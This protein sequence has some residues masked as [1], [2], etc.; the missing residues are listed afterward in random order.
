MS[1]KSKAQFKFM[2]MLEH[3]PEKMKDKPDMTSEQAAE[4][5]KENVGK[6]RFGKLIEKVKSKK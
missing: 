1:A 4:Y 6:K 3:N 5:T 2:K